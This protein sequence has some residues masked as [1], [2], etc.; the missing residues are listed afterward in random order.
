VPSRATLAGR[1]AA[2][3]VRI[4][5]GALSSTS[6]GLGALH[7]DPYSAFE[8]CFGP[9][10]ES[11]TVILGPERIAGEK[12]T[13]AHVPIARVEH[14]RRGEKMTLPLEVKLPIINGGGTQVG[15]VVSKSFL[16]LVFNFSA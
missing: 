1:R 7:L 12:P 14:G 6:L 15:Q 16:H 13:Y 3:G 4:A 5:G 2:S 10:H 11:I 8:D 9:E